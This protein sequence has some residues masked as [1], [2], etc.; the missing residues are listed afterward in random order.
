MDGCVSA[1]YS[2]EKLNDN[3]L[4]SSWLDLLY[5]G[6]NDIRHDYVEAY[7]CYQVYLLPITILQIII[8]VRYNFIITHLLR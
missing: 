4:I 3:V 2:G 6:S 8:A 1:R 5:T 7:N